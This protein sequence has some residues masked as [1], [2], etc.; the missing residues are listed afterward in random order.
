MSNQ[1]IDG[2]VQIPRWNGAI[3]MP[4]TINAVENALTTVTVAQ[5]GSI[6]FCPQS[7]HNPVAGGA[8]TINLP[9][10]SAGFNLRII[11]IAAGDGTAGHNWDITSTGANII[12]SSVAVT[13]A[14]AATD[15][16]GAT[17]ITRNAVA[18][19]ALPGDYIDLYSNGTNYFVFAYSAGAATPWAT[20]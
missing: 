19:D 20:A 5:S 1:I 4:N 3:V 14:L 18:A 8:N 9:A 12:G 17:T 2:N 7:T 13:A 10:P 16:A 11:F 15:I 6:I